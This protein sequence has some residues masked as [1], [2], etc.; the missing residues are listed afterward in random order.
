MGANFQAL[1]E[2]KRRVKELE[3]EVALLKG[4][5]EPIP[6]PKIVRSI[7]ADAVKTII[8]E[9]FPE[10]EILETAD[11]Q[12]N[13]TTVGEMNRFLAK[14]DTD[15]MQWK[16]DWPDCDDFTRRLLGNLT[17]P[18]WWGLLKGDCWVFGEGWGHS[19]LITALC[20]SETELEPKLY[21]IE[22]QSDVIELASE[23]FG[24]D[25]KVYLI[26]T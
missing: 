21:L 9:I 25:V 6:P 22:G 20:E 13:L 12:Y 2:A 7:S 19:I 10:V 8:R 4:R 24:E 11:R 23:M 17:I 26:K 3:V 15:K 1:L 5:L 18:G 16:E 14:D